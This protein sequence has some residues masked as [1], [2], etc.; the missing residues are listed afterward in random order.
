MYSDLGSMTFE[1]F[2]RFYCDGDMSGLYRNGVR[3]KDPEPDVES[4]VGGMILDSIAEAFSTDGERTA[5]LNTLKKLETARLNTIILSCAIQI[6]GT[7]RFDEGIRK[8]LKGLRVKITGDEA[9]DR[10]VLDARLNEYL[11]KMRD[12]EADMPKSDGKR[13]D[14]AWF[15]ELLTV[16]SAW[17]RFSIPHDITMGMFCGYWRQMNE[18]IRRQKKT[19][20]KN[21]NYGH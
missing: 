20:V 7:S 14:R 3:P 16:M 6:Y 21:K 4:E 8:C 1:S 15:A 2:L 9:A 13:N 18:G 17:F 5:R 10:A 11:R 12:A 19:T